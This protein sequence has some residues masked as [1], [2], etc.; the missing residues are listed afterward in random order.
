LAQKA[1]QEMGLPFGLL[2]DNPVNQSAQLETFLNTCSGKKVKFP[3]GKTYTLERQ[4]IIHD[5]NN[6]EID[7]NHCLFQLPNAYNATNRYDFGISVGCQIITFAN[8]QFVNIKN[9]KF[10]GKRALYNSGDTTASKWQTALTVTNC[11]DFTCFDFYG[12]EINYHA[13]VVYKGKN[14]SFDKLNF[15][16]N[17]LA[18]GSAGYSDVYTWDDGTD[19]NI[20]FLNTYAER[21]DLLTENTGQVYYI[22]SKNTII[23]N[24]VTK[25]VASPFDFRKGSHYVKN[26]FMNGGISLSVGSYPT[27]TEFPSITGENIECVNLTGDTTGGSALMYMTACDKAHFKNITLKAK[28]DSSVSYGLRIRKGASGAPVND[29]KNITFENLIVDLKSTS[30]K[31]IYFDSLTKPVQIYNVKLIGSASAH[32][33]LRTYQCTANMNVENVD[34]EGTFVIPYE[35]ADNQ[36]R[37]KN[38][39]TFG[40]SAPATKP[41]YISQEYLDTTNK[42]KYIAY[43][44]A[45]TADWI[46]SS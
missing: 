14:I 31:L 27:N 16:N 22:N 32:N 36:L 11:N 7:F 30:A 34:L 41:L 8:S 26:V 24:I 19:C 3:F 33:A 18:G 38:P 25:N 35:A 44:T 13:I 2:I 37:I 28:A 5:V 17:G 6:I 21:T 23:E 9:I 29:L 40:S 10:D 42:K 12:K 4:L 43:G 45:S 15:Y 20:T 39:I 46:L 1:M